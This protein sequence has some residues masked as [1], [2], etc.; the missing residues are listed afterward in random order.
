[1][2]EN[3][4]VRPAQ[5][6]ATLMVLSAI[7]IGVAL[8]M[9]T[10]APG[11]ADAAEARAIEAQ[12]VRDADLPLLYSQINRQYFSSQ[13]PEYVSV[14]WSD[15]VADKDCNACA[16]MTDWDTGFPRIRLDPKSIRSEKFLREA[17]EHEMCHVATVDDAT[18]AHEDFHGPLFQSCMQRY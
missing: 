8:L 2:R 14:S 12:Q 15:L 7:Y 9:P 1:L 4:N 10:G 6:A 11:G 17:M 13:L 3:R 5:Y 16:G 18:K